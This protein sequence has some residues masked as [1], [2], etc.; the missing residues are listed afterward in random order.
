MTRECIHLGMQNH[1][2]SNGI[3]REIL[4][5]ISDLIV[6]EVSK[7][8]T[9]KNSA[10]AMAASKEFLDKYLIHSGPGPKKIL[11]GQEFVDVLDKFEH[12]SSPNLGNMILPSRGATKEEPMIASWLC[13]GLPQ[14]NTSMAMSFQV[15]ARTRCTFS[16]CW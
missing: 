9:A 2:I 13:K 12:L 10:I 16:R 11:R 6:H 3:C 4:D 5:T 8:P 7:T 14:L 15:K 1:P